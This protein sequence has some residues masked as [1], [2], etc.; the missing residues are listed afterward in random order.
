MR[1]Y[2]IRILHADKTTDLI[3]EMTHLTDSAAIRAGRDMAEARPFE[4]WRDL[5]CIYGRPSK[6]PG[7]AA[8][9]NSPPL[10]NPKPDNGGAGPSA[11]SG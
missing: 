7:P 1:E 2:E 6:T 10:H 4:V 11:S 3:I 5:Q 8:Q 9:L